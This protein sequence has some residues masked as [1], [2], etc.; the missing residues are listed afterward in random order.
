MKLSGIE[1]L[2]GIRCQEASIHSR[3]TYIACGKPAVA[4]I[5]HEKDKRAYPMC[6]PCSD[7][8]VRNRGGRLLMTCEKA[9]LLKKVR[10]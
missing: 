4:V 3:E 2:A 1:I 7:H 10:P 5:W 8:N 9:L 6:H